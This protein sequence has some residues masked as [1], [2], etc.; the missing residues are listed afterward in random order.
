MA[1]ATVVGQE[2]VELALRAI[3]AHRCNLPGTARDIFQQLFDETS[4]RTL[5]DSDDLAAWDFT[6]IARCY[7]VLL[8]E[9]EPATALEAF[10]RA[11]PDGADRTPGLD[12]LVRFMVQTLGDGNFRIERVLTDLVRFRPGRMG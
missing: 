2:T 4:A 12:D 8:G 11:R 10:R 5:A 1:A 9:A 6:G 7:P 3:I